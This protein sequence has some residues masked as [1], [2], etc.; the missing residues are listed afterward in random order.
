M[1]TPPNQFGAPGPGP[2]P[3][4]AN[5]LDL[6][7]SVLKNAPFRIL[8]FWA[9]FAAMVGACL[10]MI[11]SEV[12]FG[13]AVDQDCVFSS[14][15]EW[16][17]CEQNNCSALAFRTRSILMQASGDGRPC[18]NARLIE[19][20]TC[21]FLL[22]TCAAIACQY[23]PWG[24]WSTCPD[25]CMESP[26]DCGN[27]ATRIRTRSVLR[28]SGPGGTPCDWTSLVQTSSC[29]APAFCSV[30]RECI[31]AAP[32]PDFSQCPIGCPSIGCTFS[33]KPLFTM[34]TTSNSLG[35]DEDCQPFQLLYSRSCP[36]PECSDQCKN[37]NYSYFSRCSV[38]CGAGTQVTSLPS[39]CPNVTTSS[40]NLG[41]CATGA[42]DLLPT[43]VTQTQASP[44]TICP[45]S[46]EDIL[47]RGFSLSRCL[48]QCASDPQCSYAWASEGY[49][50]VTL[51]ALP[52][53]TLQGIVTDMW[54]YNSLST[55]CVV[56]NWDMA[57][58]TCLYICESETENI[59]FN[60]LTEFLGGVPYNPDRGLVFP[61]SDGTQSCPIKPPM[62]Q[63][64]C[65]VSTPGSRNS[66]LG[67]LPYL[68]EQYSQSSNQTVEIDGV[69]YMCPTS[70]PCIYESWSDAAP[71]GLCS[72]APHETDEGIRSRVRR[73][74][75]PPTFL[76]DACDYQNMVETAPCNRATVIGS[77][78]EMW[79][80]V[81][82]LNTMETTTELNCFIACSMSR[83]EN[84]P[85]TCNSLFF[86]Q[87][88]T[89]STVSEVFVISLS[90]TIT[91]AGVSTITSVLP[92]GYRLAYYAEVAEAWSSGFQF[93]AAP[94]WA[95]SVQSNPNS[96]PLALVSAQQRTCS[97]FAPNS[98]SDRTA[99]IGAGT[100]YAFLWGIKSQF[101]GNTT[102]TPR[103]GNAF[104]FFTPT[105]EP[106]FW[107]SEYDLQTQQ[108][109]SDVYCAAFT[110]RTDIL[111]NASSCSALNQRASTSNLLDVPY[112]YAKDCSATAWVNVQDC[113]NCIADSIS[114]RSYV[115][116]PSQGGFPCNR[117][118]LVS[119]TK[120][121]PYTC[122]NA[123]TDVCIPQSLSTRSEYE[124]SCTDALFPADVYLE[125]WADTSV[126]SWANLHWSM[127]TLWPPVGGGPT[128]P[129]A[130]GTLSKHEFFTRSIR[131]YANDPDVRI[132]AQLLDALN[133]NCGTFS[134]LS[135]SSPLT[136]FSLTALGWESST[137][138]ICQPDAPQLCYNR[139]GLAPNP[140]KQVYSGGWQCPST[141]RQDGLSLSCNVNTPPLP[142]C[143]CIH[144]WQSPPITP[145]PEPTPLNIN[146]LFRSFAVGNQ[147]YFNCSDGT[148]NQTY[149]FR[150][151][152][153]D[154]TPCAENPQCPL[155]IDGSMCNVASGFGECTDLQ[156]N[157]CTCNPPPSP[158]N[159][160]SK[161]CDRGCR[162]NPVNNQT[163]TLG[164]GLCVYTPGGSFTCNCP[165]GRY[166][167][168]CE[169]AG[170]G[171]TGLAEV[172]Y[173]QAET[174]FIS[175]QNTA[176]K[177]YF[178]FTNPEPRC[179]DGNP[180]CVGSQL[181]SPPGISHPYYD[182]FTRNDVWPVFSNICV[183][184]NDAALNSQ[185]W[186]SAKY[187]TRDLVNTLS[188]RV[189]CEEYQER[190]AQ[191]LH[192]PFTLTAKFRAHPLIPPNLHNKQFYTRCQ[193]NDTNFESGQYKFLADRL[194]QKDS[195]GAVIFDIIQAGGRNQGLTLL[196]DICSGGISGSAI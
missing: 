12:K 68:F 25:T 36:Y 121:D 175:P 28:T 74:L 48:A 124:T 92:A 97:T 117:T 100:R 87:P 6:S 29:P 45:A 80:S 176:Q 50:N 22:N 172:L 5:F 183:N 47:S 188:Q 112:E 159:M 135:A 104:P 8:L 133:A 123:F 77:A 190:E 38:P 145:S 1:Q 101:Q 155:G 21:D 131:S 182:F 177:I 62:L 94:A 156:N 185:T 59:S 9:V 26:Q 37:N 143:P 161:T 114:T 174:P 83:A 125:S 169:T 14:Y 110:D 13:D 78:S 120:C 127:T 170:F 122:T 99:L 193:N 70:T 95:L 191:G 52:P 84:G 139:M 180:Y 81:S 18:Q 138:P 178:S 186:V 76:G 89:L 7:K 86:W 57:A 184:S 20:T 82:S 142:S 32:A 91:Q 60:H 44:E 109:Q 132:N 128:P 192:Y 196:T 96:T 11:V 46:S 69:D 31:P 160:D 51:S 126:Y 16:Q 171:I 179:E 55:N 61:F 49:D 27:V 137:S 189:N 53:V 108:Y 2:D 173:Y 141:C 34:C 67:I 107:D 136:Y 134:C 15:S 88:G 154:Y 19:T 35:P 194:P 23:S 130:F 166:G 3:P 10:T 54:S 113:G 103:T 158:A 157:T 163:C 116:P 164:P 40:C 149:S 71:W 42:M 43:P 56:P 33:D 144:P 30:T 181:F 72:Q 98:L 168:V 129:P 153:S 90:D 75:R 39:D 148:A 162:V 105:T 93:C 41:A 115:S 85:D 65:P 17:G 63:E 106:L 147:N 111:L 187:L 58:A 102:T 73:V 146:L 195:T 64:I 167:D 24:E 151:S 150:C 118:F 165:P 140:G 152:S 79:C 4:N 66:G 119:V